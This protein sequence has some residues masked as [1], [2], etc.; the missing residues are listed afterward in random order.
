MKQI[1]GAYARLTDDTDET[2]EYTALV[3]KRP[4]F[5]TQLDLN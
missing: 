5:R 2:D 1:R 4:K 3:R